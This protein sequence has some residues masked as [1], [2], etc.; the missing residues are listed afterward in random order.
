MP[1]RENN[2]PDRASLSLYVWMGCWA[3]LLMA[4]FIFLPTKLCSLLNTEISL[5]KMTCN[6]K[7]LPSCRLPLN[8]SF[9]FHSYLLSFTNWLL[10]THAF[11]STNS[12]RLTSLLVFLSLPVF[13]IPVL[14]PAFKKYPLILLCFTTFQC[15]QHPICSFLNQQLPSSVFPR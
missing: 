5:T 2:C 14:S 7:K 13:V 1:T 15:V 3:L 6:I 11:Q 9:L 4:A 8:L 10:G 12:W